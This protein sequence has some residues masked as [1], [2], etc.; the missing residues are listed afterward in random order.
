MLAAM[1]VA[2]VRGMAMASNE[3]RMRPPSIG[4]AGIRLKRKSIAFTTI[5][6]LLRVN[7]MGPPSNG[8]STK[9][10]PARSRCTVP[11]RSTIARFTRGPARVIRNSC[12]GSSGMRSRLATPP[13]G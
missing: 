1:R 5:R 2:R 12:F 6:K 13:I 10:S 4:N 7:S 9:R 8:S 3:R 11:A